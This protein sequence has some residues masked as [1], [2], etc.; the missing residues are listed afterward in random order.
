MVVFANSKGG[1]GKST[2][3]V[4]GAV[5]LHDLGFTTALLDAD[6]Q[7]SSS[8]WM[9][10]AEPQIT[11]ATANTAEEC[12]LKAQELGSSH[13]FVVGDAPG[14][15]E[16]LSRTLL[17]LADL[18][19]FPISPS[20]LDV[21]SVLTATEVLRYA[22]TIRGGLPKGRLVLNKMRTRGRISKQLQQEAPKLGL[23]VASSSV[24]NL[25]AYCDAPQQGTVVSRLGRRG[26]V[27]AAELNQL[28]LELFKD[29]L[30]AKH[31]TE[32]RKIGNG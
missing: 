30:P 3:A 31:L 16:D 19:V 23:E 24:R 20:I 18:A 28:Y 21:R 17:I 9:A 29:W 8:V 4:H 15:L 12:A 7:R 27:A 2:H 13:D 14:G 11:I 25:E 22:Q 5:W 26:A 6:K 32:R 1:V 10:E